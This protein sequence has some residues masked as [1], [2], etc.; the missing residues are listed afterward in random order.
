MSFIA[1]AVGDLRAAANYSDIASSYF[2]QWEQFAIDPSGTHT[3]LAYQRR[4]SYGLLYNTSPDKFLPLGSI[5][6][7]LYDMQ[8]DW[9]PTISQVFGVRSSIIFP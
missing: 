2:A 5:P 8:S 3:M 9:Y 6:Q 1:E 4:G 7:S